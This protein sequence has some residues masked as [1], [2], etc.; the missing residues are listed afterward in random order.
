MANIINVRIYLINNG[1]KTLETPES[2]PDVITKD[3]GLDND[4]Q[5][6]LAAKLTVKEIFKNV[7]KGMQNNEDD[8]DKR[9]FIEKLLNAKIRNVLNFLKWCATLIRQF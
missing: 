7:W 3:W 5:L 6:H 8:Q 4:Q 2:I 9:K 1:L